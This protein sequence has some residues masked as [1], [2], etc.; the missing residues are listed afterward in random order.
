MSNS[1]Q[2]TSITAATPTRCTRVFPYSKVEGAS[3]TK[4]LSIVDGSV[5]RYS[6]ASAIWFFDAPSSPS[7][8]T[9]SL[10]LSLRKTLDI[11]P[12]W[13]GSL[14]M[15]DPNVVSDCAP[16]TQR[17][18]RPQLTWGAVDDPGVEFIE[19]RS[20]HTLSML[21]NPVERANSHRAW[22]ASPL[23]ALGTL[24]ATSKLALHDRKSSKGLPCMTVQI[25]NFACGGVAIAVKFAHPLA[26]AQTLLT[27][28]HD[29]AKIHRGLSVPAR[30]FA[31][32]L[33]DTTAEGDIDAPSPNHEILARSKVVPLH[34]FDWW[35]S[36]TP[37][38]PPFMRSGTEIPAPVSSA[39]TVIVEPGRPLPWKTWDILAPARPYFVYFTHAE[40]IRMWEAAFAAVGAGTLGSGSPKISKLD[41]L[42]AHIWTLIIRARNL[43]GDQSPVNLDVT[44]GLRQRVS[45]PL[46]VD[47]LGS[48]ILNVPVTQ[49]ASQVSMASAAIIRSSMSSYD[50]STLAALLH[51]MAYAIDPSRRWNAFLG[52]RHTIVTSWL[53]SRPGMAIYDVDFGFGSRAKIVHPLMPECDGCIQ[54]MESGL[55]FE[56]A[57]TSSW[58]PWYKTGVSVSLHLRED[59]MANLLADP[60]LRKYDK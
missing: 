16:H 18:N 27:F 14:H 15:P 38:C 10:L 43:S 57:Q 49:P 30:E 6:P 36:A 31:P 20:S 19:S 11:Y 41:A 39:P 40:I 23:A 28:V 42:L 9:E 2:L 60:W 17:Y 4:A 33:L 55:E 12:Q 13:A 37:D 5:L 46:P 52:D 26:D 8:D 58:I 48:P 59:V 21:P 44:I 3:S 7:A 56:G 51:E 50:S 45:P 35:A 53:E 1:E 47:F 32:Q 29:W 24:S 34:R 54:I 22:D 25:T